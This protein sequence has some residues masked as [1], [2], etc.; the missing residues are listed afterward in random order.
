LLE[1][2]LVAKSS[3]EVRA[4]T[5]ILWILIEVGVSHDATILGDVNT[6][7]HFAMAKYRHGPMGRF[8]L[9]SPHQLGIT[10]L[11]PPPRPQ[12]S[13]RLLYQMGEMSPGSSFRFG[14]RDQ[15]ASP[16]TINV[17]LS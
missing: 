2:F 8:K 15:G 12:H 9:H 11:C 5:K 4:L 17:L 16:V 7:K 6:A 13:V 14:R 3:N 1:R 10:D